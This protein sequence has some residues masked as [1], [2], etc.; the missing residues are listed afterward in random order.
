MHQRCVMSFKPAVAPTKVGIYPL[1]NKEE[2]NPYI[3]KICTSLM[4][5]GKYTYMVVLIQ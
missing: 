1:I 3:T 4:E 2:F 5:A